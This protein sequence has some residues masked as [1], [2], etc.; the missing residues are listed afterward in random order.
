MARAI[1]KPTGY[2]AAAKVAQAWASCSSPAS[3]LCPPALFTQVSISPLRLFV[4]FRY[5]LFALVQHIAL[6]KP[7]S[8]LFLQVCGA[9]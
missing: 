5:H 2:M 9:G 3:Q 4:I 7:A 6:T 1:S 8:V